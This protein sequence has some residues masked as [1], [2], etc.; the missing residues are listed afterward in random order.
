MDMNELQEIVRAAIRE[1]L[2][3]LL[4]AAI[5]RAR[6]RFVDAA[7]LARWTGL[8]VRTIRNMQKDGR[9]P[10]VRVGRRVLFDLDD[11]ERLITAGK[12]PTRWTE[13]T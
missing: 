11:V 1:E 2:E 9:L 4:P 7:E 3:A 12:I 5:R 10:Y 6:R 8:S 13:T